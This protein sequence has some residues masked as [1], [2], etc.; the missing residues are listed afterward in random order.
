[1]WYR[2][3]SLVLI[4]TSIQFCKYACIL[5]SCSPL[6]KWTRKRLPYIDLARCIVIAIIAWHAREVEIPLLRHGKKQRIDTLINEETL[7]LARV[8]RKG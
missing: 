4:I 5:W 6:V 7:L 2:A 1:M 3:R 8:K